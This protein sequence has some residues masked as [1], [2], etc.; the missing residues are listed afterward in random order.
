MSKEDRNTVDRFG[1]NAK[2]A[3]MYTGIGSQRIYQPL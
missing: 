1:N 2:D 3:G